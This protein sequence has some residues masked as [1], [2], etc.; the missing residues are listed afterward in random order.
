MTALFSLSTEMSKQIE[1]C[2][3]SKTCNCLLPALCR[4]MLCRV[5]ESASLFVCL[6]VVC[7]TGPNTA[8]DSSS[9]SKHT[10]A[11]KGSGSSHKSSSSSKGSDSSKS[12]G[13]SHKSSSAAA[14]KKAK[15][16]SSW[17]DLDF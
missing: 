7:F 4:D 8:I 10:T 13:S 14:T 5:P 12:S 9:P 17:A 1:M 2:V 6:S 16:A 11:H 15:K 3:W